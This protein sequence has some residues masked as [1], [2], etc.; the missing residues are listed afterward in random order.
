[1][2]LAVGGNDV[3]SDKRSGQ[4]FSYVDLEQRVRQNH[5]VRTSAKS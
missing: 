3:G 1:M 2:L 5:P 4:L